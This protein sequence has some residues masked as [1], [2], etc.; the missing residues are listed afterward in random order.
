MTVRQLIEHLQT[1]DERLEIFVFTEGEFIEPD[2]FTS[3][4]RKRWGIANDH[5]MAEN[6][7]FVYI[8]G[9]DVDVDYTGG[10]ER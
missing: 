6:Q 4:W 7:P 5:R 8:D 10:V 3:H 1:Y 9:G 2:I